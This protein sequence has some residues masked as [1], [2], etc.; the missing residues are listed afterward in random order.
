MTE[1]GLSDARWRKSSRSHQTGACVEVAGNI[2]GI[3]A[4]R[5]SKDARGPTLVFSPAAWQAF[6]RDLR[7]QR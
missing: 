4:V 7:K 6:T 2:P 5:D 3:V 1:R